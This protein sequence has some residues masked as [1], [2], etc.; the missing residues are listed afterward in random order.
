MSDEFRTHIELRARDLEHAGLTPNAALLA[1]RREFGSTE[2]YKEQGRASRGLRRIDQLRF[3][4][5]D[6]KLGLRML[7][8]Y[9][10]LTI[11]GGVAVAFAISGGAATFEFIGQLVN[12]RLPLPDG[13]RVVA[14]RNWNLETNWPDARSL[15]DFTAWR[16][17]L[18]T[19]R[20]IGAAQILER[21]LSVDNGP[22]EP[23]EVAEISASA[24]PLTRVPPLLG[25]T[26]IE[27]DEQAGAPLV[28]V[29]GYNLW[30]SR[31]AGDPKVVGRTVRVG[32]AQ[33]TVVGVMPEGFGFPVAQELWLPLR[34]N[35][36]E[37]ERGQGPALQVFGRLAPGATLEEAQ[38]EL[39]ALGR[40]AATDFPE[41]HEHLRPQ[42]LLHAKRWLMFST[43]ETLGVLS[44][45][46][47]G[48]FLLVLIC[49]NVALLMFAR[50]ATRES[51]IIVRSALGASRGR[52]TMQLFAEALVLFGVATA[53]GL[54]AARFGLGWALNVA[55]I[56]MNSD[57]GHLP[58]WITDG[59]SS[60][61]L[62]YA[63]L[64][65][66][67]GAALAGV[68]PALKITRGL[69]AN[70]KRISARPR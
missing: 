42:V 40:R 65:A 20:E 11:V 50:A 8:K 18:R 25:R 10:G 34:L 17:E 19:V 33:A 70:L 1:A 9:P 53:V 43:A 30:Q 36:L 22:G 54:A 13:Q 51:E 21:N 32:R 26:L 46:L 31:F 49:A 29:I 48:V 55:E 47:F 12:P 3:S 37:H 57:G 27:S 5:L 2:L 60:T 56:E 67:L 6:F 24:F 45:N 7:V 41:T 38:V 58:F 66:L 4:W 69:S 39:A 52:I 61:T 63:L 64:L 68:V 35:V 44:F 59:L 14:L 62:L 16:T 15:H 28:A 23:A